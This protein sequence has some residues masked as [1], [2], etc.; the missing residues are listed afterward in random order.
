MTK[1]ELI[2]RKKFKRLASRRVVALLKQ[3]QLINNLNNPYTYSFTPEQ[4]TKIFQTIEEEVQFSK[5]QFEN[6]K[7]LKF[8]L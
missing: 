4:I 3:L 5:K 7:S 8:Q 6:S 2:K 1:K